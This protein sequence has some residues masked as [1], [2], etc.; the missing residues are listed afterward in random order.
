[1]TADNGSETPRKLTE[2]L[3]PSIASASIF[4]HKQ[5]FLCN[6]IKLGMLCIRFIRNLYFLFIF[7]RT[8]L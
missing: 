2:Y 8:L 7:C 5:M 4:N 1:M 3:K 6:T